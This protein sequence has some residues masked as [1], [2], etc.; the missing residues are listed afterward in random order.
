MTLIVTVGTREN[1]FQAADTRLT[2]IDGSFYYDENIKT[3]VVHCCDSKLLFSYTGLGVIENDRTD[4]WLAKMLSKNKVWK[5]TF[6]EC[7]KFVESELNKAKSRDKNLSRYD[8]TFNIGGLGI[9]KGQRDIAWALITNNEEYVPKRGL[10]NHKTIRDGFGSVFFHP[11]KN[12]KVHWSVYGALDI[13]SEMKALKRQIETKIVDV[14]TPKQ[15]DEIMNLIV[16]VIKAQRK[17]SKVGGLISEDCTV[18][19]IGTDYKGSLF[20]FNKEE[21]KKRFPNIVSPKYTI[22]DKK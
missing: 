17:S 5:K 15:L 1:I 21:G 8:L 9:N 19:H 3:T 16:D 22:I 2:A 12:F 6:P 11:Y 7:V 10:T 13:N 18:A 4:I 14:K 20:S